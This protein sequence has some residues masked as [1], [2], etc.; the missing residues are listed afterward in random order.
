MG[1]RPSE[2]DANGNA[3]NRVL[4]SLCPAPRYT[5]TTQAAPTGL[6]AVPT[7]DMLGRGE[8]SLEVERCGKRLLGTRQEGDDEWIVNLSCYWE[9]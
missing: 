7:A 9:A 8:I 4:C 5:T 3:G 1:H 2:D 6:V